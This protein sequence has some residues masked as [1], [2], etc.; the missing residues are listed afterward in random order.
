LLP[1]ADVTPTL[2]RQKAV[3]LEL[4]EQQTADTASLVG[5]IQLWERAVN[6]INQL[7]STTPSVAV[8]EDSSRPVI[9]AGAA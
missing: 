4:V 2:R 1:L 5:L 9:S 6:S 7:A 3:F 8:A